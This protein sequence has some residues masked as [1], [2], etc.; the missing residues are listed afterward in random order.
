MTCCREERSSELSSIIPNRNCWRGSLT[1]GICEGG[2]ERKEE[3]KEGGEV[4]H[5]TSEARQ[6]HVMVIT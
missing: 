5:V 2:R 6:L 4:E 3:R 1:E